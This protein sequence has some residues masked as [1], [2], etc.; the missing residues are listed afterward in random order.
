MMLL[1]TGPLSFPGRS[2][3]VPVLDITAEHEALIRRILEEGEPVR[4]RVE[5]QNRFTPGEVVS[6]NIVG[7]IP[8]TQ[9]AEEIVILGA[10]LDSWDL[11]TGTI[12]DG[13]GVAAILGAARSIV[14]SGVKPNRTI[15]VVLFTGEEQGLFGSRAY[16]QQHRAEANNFLCAIVVDWG[17]GPITKFLLGG[18]DEFAAPLADF[19]N[20]IADLALLRTENGYLTYTDAYSFI[21]AGIPGITPFQDSPNYALIGHSAADTLDKVD[22]DIL[23]RDSALLAVSSFWI[24]NN[25]TRLGTRWSPERTV[26]MLS[27]QRTALQSLGLWPFSK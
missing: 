19:F 7:E 6:T 2:S 1:H 23:D 3:M 17:S 25:P 22:A 27:E 21:F 16:V 12:D 9:Q 8:G 26:E 20:S 10:H 14:A 13:F 24:A 15:R 18:H 11:G 4:L 5:I